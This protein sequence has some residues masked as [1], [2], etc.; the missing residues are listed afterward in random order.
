MKS[1][2]LL[3]DFTKYCQERPELRFWQALRNW[4]VYNFI[5]VTDDIENISSNTIKDTFYWEE[6][7]K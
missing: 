3:D 4:T 7:D 5:V 6:K 1:K 2:K